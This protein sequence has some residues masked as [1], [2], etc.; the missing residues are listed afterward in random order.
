MKT[1]ISGPLN[2]T[3]RKQLFLPLDVKVSVDALKHRA[4]RNLRQF[5]RLYL[6]QAAAVDPAFRDELAGRDA[7]AA[8]R[9]LSRQVPGGS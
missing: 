4:G 2:F 9:T 3:L 1:F 7:S 6:V 8:P 5:F